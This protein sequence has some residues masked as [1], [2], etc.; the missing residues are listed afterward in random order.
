[1]AVAVRNRNDDGIVIGIN[2]I[3]F[4]ID[5]QLFIEYQFMQRAIGC[6]S[7]FAFVYSQCAMWNKWR[8]RRQTIEYVLT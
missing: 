4:A 6:G 5:H 1:M 7:G 8:M 2:K 3:G